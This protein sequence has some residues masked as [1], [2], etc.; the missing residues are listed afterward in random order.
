MIK[1]TTLFLFSLF[2]FNNLFAQT[3]A[4]KAQLDTA[5][6]MGSKI[7]SIALNKQQTDNL[8]LLGKIWGFLKY[9]HP[10]VAASNLNWDFELFRILPKILA[11]ATNAER[12]KVLATWIDNLGTVPPYPAPVCEVE[13]DTRQKPDYTWINAKNM[14]QKLVDKLLFIQQNR[15]IGENYYVKVWDTGAPPDF[16]NENAY[17][18]TNY[19][20]AGFRLLSLYRFWNIIQ[21]YYPYKYAI[22]EETWDNVLMRLMPN[23][24]EAKNAE[25]YRLAV[26]AL[27]S[28]V[29]DS[30]IVLYQEPMIQD[31]KPPVKIRFVGDNAVVSEILEMRT[32]NL[33]LGDVIIEKNGEKIANIVQKMLFFT[34]A[35]NKATQLRTIGQDLLCTKESEIKLKILRDDE[36]MDIVETTIPYFYNPPP[37]PKNKNGLLTS[38][39][40]Y[41]S[42]GNINIRTLTALMVKMH[43]TKGL[44]LD[45]RNYPQLMMVDLWQF[46]ESLMSHKTAYSQ[47]S[48]TTKDCPGL[49]HFDIIQ[50]IGKEGADYY[51]GKIVILVNDYTQSKAELFAMALRKA[52]KAIVMGSQTA[53]AD[54][55]FVGFSLPGG[56]NTGITGRGVYY[57]DGKE[58]QRIGIVPDITVKPTIQGIKAGKD[59]VLE[60]AIEYIQKD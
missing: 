54:G 43:E 3:Q 29:H 45:L 28:A 36:E 15:F 33:Q 31:N 1:K 10:S 48:N 47:F 7:E 35:S 11:T 59:E 41:I 27:L 42:L 13:T 38:D 21:Y 30:H 46:G 52:P 58:T 32:S 60:K 34:P 25:D 9:H 14:S 39:I 4:F 19:P 37:T 20:D 23:F 22:T 5:F 26:L 24:V 50:E 57:P 55:P 56:Y 40:A 18:H 51:K 53:G 6:D 49:F 8:V 12:D 16:T 17:S 44:V 2:I